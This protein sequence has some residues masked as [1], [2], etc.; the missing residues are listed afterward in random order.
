MGKII[1]FQQEAYKPDDGT[2]VVKILGCEYKLLE[3]EI[4]DWLGLFGDVITEISEEP[5][6]ETDDTTLPPV[7]N[8]N[9]LVTIR[10]KKDLPNYLPIYGRKIC[11]EYK[12]VRKQCNACFGFHLRKFCK[13][14][15]MGMEEFT[16]KF[17][18]LHPN[19]PEPF[20][21]IRLMLLVIIM[22]S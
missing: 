19:L 21:F 18:I 5:Y 4:L 2:R 15:R 12:G 14:E 22:N 8:G 16:D 20:Y 9:Y 1:L 7:G 3:S 10:L 11:L 13:Y 17:R 6:G